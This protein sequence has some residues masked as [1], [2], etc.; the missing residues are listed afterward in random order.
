[1]AVKTVKD[2]TSDAKLTAQK[3]LPVAGRFLS[4]FVNTTS[5]AVSYGVVLQAVLIA[6]TIPAH[7]LIVHGFVDGAQSANDMVAQMKNHKLKLPTASV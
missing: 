6:K 5:Y 1:M 2:G 3:M 4:R 7:E